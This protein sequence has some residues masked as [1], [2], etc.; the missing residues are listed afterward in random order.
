MILGV[1][2]KLWFHSETKS[3]FNQY[4]HLHVWRSLCFTRKFVT[5]VECYNLSSMYKPWYKLSHIWSLLEWY[6]DLSCN[7]PLHWPNISNPIKKSYIS[8][9]PKYSLVH[10][11][12]V[13][14]QW[15]DKHSYVTS[16]ALNCASA[17]MCIIQSFKLMSV[18]TV[19]F[20][21]SSL[22]LRR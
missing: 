18:R 14:R 7:Y 13:Q 16:M 3:C 22:L 15:R 21:S 20:F 5:A 11:S 4:G 19:E 9:M 17:W 8:L 6:S 12:S 2:K 10:P 1:C